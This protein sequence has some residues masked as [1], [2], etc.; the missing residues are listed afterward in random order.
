MSV[1]TE[2]VLIDKLS[3]MSN[4]QQSIE[5]LSHWILYHRKHVDKSVKVWEKEIF[6]A[7]PERKILFLYLANHV[8]QSSRKKGND[9]IQAFSKIIKPCILHVYRDG[10]S[11]KE[12]MRVLDLWKERNVLSLNFV[13]DIKRSLSGQ[14]QSQTPIPPRVEPQNVASLP[15]ALISSSQQLPMDPNFLAII[16]ALQVVQQGEM[17]NLF[18]QDE[19]SS[20]LAQKGNPISSQN[21]ELYINE[22]IADIERRNEVINKV[23]NFLEEQKH[24][25]SNRKELLKQLYE[26]QS[27]YS[28]PITSIGIKRGS[29]LSNNNEE[30]HPQK[31]NKN[32]K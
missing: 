9:F 11:Q 25:V 14:H 2:Q 27:S 26:L 3:H 21:S 13:E 5:T 17:S 8:M 28:G 29:D 1:F 16:D 12:V 31:K 19:I 22:L 10:N 6:K 15:T 24:I 18:L 7:P 20:L 32:R 23:S 30:S 4:S